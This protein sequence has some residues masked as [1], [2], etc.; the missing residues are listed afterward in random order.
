MPLVLEAVRFMGSMPR[1]SSTQNPGPDPGSDMHVHTNMHAH[2]CCA[3]SRAAWPWARRST[4]SSSGSRRSTPPQVRL[5]GKG[6]PAQGACMLGGV[7]LVEH[8]AGMQRSTHM[9]GVLGHLPG[10][11]HV[12]E[13]RSAVRSQA[14]HA[15]THMHR[16]MAC[17]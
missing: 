13:G 4:S 1:G 12:P 3:A 10:A 16:V 6:P 2:R 15:C 7:G 9:G 5:L 11:A 8:P 14:G 17:D